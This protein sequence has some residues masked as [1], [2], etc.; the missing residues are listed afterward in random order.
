MNWLILLT[1]FTTSIS[2]AVVNIDFSTR[3]LLFEGIGSI[4]GGGVS[5]YCAKGKTK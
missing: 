3:G 2:A 4:S 1:L 5:D